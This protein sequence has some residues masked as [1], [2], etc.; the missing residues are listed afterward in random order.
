MAQATT[1]T[2]FYPK[3]GVLTRIS[4]WFWEAMATISENNPRLRRVRALQALSDAQLAELKIKREEIVHHVFK[5]VYY[6]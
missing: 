6:V 5:D 4:A 3:A 2:D 1:N